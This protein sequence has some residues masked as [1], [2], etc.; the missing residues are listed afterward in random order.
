[1]FV[2]NII[3]LWLLLGMPKL[4]RFTSTF[5]GLPKLRSPHFSTTTRDLHIIQNCTNCFFKIASKLFLMGL[6]ICFNPYR[7]FRMF[8][9]LCALF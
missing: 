5:L 4:F 1:M 6:E 7:I 2:N 9:V 8:V 3:V